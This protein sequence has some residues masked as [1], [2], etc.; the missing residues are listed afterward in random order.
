MALSITN[1]IAALNAYQNLTNVQDSLTSSIAKLSSGNA[2]TTAG[3]NA[4]GLAI[5]TGLT[6]QVNG[7]NVAATNAQ[8][9]L[10]VVQTASGA[11]TQVTSM[12]QRLR[13]LAVQSANDSN[14]AASRSDISTEATQITAE[15]TRVSTATN[16]N[17]TNLLD[18][19]A[20]ALNF[21]VGA[22]G[23]A[24]NTISVNLTSANVGAVA[25]ALG[26]LDFS[27]NAGST[28]AISTIDTQLATVSTAQATLGA[29][30]NRFSDAIASV[31]VASQ[32]LNAASSQITSTDMAKQMVTF[33]GEQVQA[34]AAT[35]ILA[36]ANQLPQGIL[37]L[38]Q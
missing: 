12:L 7:L 18:G 37:K 14:S 33:T 23:S 8:S 34:Q 25:T 1:N 4:A 13:D 26:S 31:N 16:Y 5:A 32:N 24:D 3:D 9:G 21:Q 20:T 30:Q 35:A 19:S 38:L 6:S 29:V 17:G 15:L 28:A 22:N 10:D 27:T 2:I 36:Q 11:L